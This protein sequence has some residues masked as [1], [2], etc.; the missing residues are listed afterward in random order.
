ML[1]IQEFEPSYKTLSTDIPR[2]SMR[3]E[4][5]GLRNAEIERSCDGLCFANAAGASVLYN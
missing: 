3:K 4:F 1:I 5:R 2:N